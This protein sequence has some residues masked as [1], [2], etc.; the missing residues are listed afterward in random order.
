MF[1]E[2]IFR[3]G[4][5]SIKWD[6]YNNEE[7]IAM[8]T[9]D[10]DFISPQ[11]ITEAL[12]N[13]AKLG[14]FAY[15]LKSDSYYNAIIDW[16]VQRYNWRIK[17]EWLSNSPGIWAGV[18][19]CIDS[20]TE[21]GDKIMAHSPTFHPVIDIVKKSRRDLVTNSLVL[22]DGHYT[23]DFEDFESKIADN[24]KIFILVNPH[25]PSGRV[26]TSEELTRIGEI[27]NK[28]KV[29][30]L[31][32][33]VHGGVVFK[34]HKHIPY[35]SISEEFAMNSIIIT[36][37]SKSFNLQGLTHGILII[38]NKKLLDIY[39]SA[40]IG[41]D[42]DFAT[43][44]FSL[45]AVEAAYRHGGPWLDE[46]IIYLQ[47]N[48]HYLIDYFEVNIPKIKVIKPEGSYMVWLD[49]RELKMNKDEVEN[50]FMTKAKV[51]LTFGSGFGKDGERF[52][53]INIACSRNLLNEALERIK[54]AV[55]SI[56]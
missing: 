26:F 32:D 45:A 42:F 25:N 10:M 8:G 48:L 13:R 43:N 39:E 36:A 11:C 30:V 33:E 6:R 38:P 16:Y 7:I 4:T 18:R 31:S 56:T 1:D 40:L 29:L 52:A 17:K 41:Y 12:I 23:I 55:N 15:E 35:G 53:R 24:V 19:I 37:A 54:E 21:P 3:L 28:H 14:M 22:K 9:A 49:C 47:S 44:I 20:F 51:A 50:F 34:G 46:L 5:N 27:C 2:R